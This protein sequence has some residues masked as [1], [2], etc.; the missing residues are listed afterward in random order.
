MAMVS[1]K[2]SHTLNTSH[3]D[4]HTNT[5]RHAHMN[6]M[7]PNQPV[8]GENHSAVGHGLRHEVPHEAAHSLRIAKKCKISH[9][10]TE[11]GTGVASAGS[12]GQRAVVLHDT[13]G[14]LEDGLLRDV[15]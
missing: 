14:R 8:G 3:T 10:F 4:M 13:P 5:H 7:F 12:N 1:D 9:I 2:K 6:K 11:S 15:Q